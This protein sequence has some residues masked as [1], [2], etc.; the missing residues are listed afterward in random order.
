[1]IGSRKKVNKP[2]K[3]RCEGSLLIAMKKKITRGLFNPNSPFI[4]LPP[5]TKNE[6]RINRNPSNLM[7]VMRG[8]EPPTP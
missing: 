7:V 2:Y 8:Y 3:I 4:N 6:L 1:M 5:Q